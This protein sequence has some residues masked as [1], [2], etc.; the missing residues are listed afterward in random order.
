MHEE[1]HINNQKSNGS[2]NKYD[3]FYGFVSLYLVA[4]PDLQL[5]GEARGEGGAR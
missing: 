1:M 5:R 4:D 2:H 3:V